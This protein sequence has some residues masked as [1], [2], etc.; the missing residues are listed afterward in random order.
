[1][2]FKKSIVLGLDSSEF[3]KGM[4]SANSEVDKFSDNLDDAKSSIDSAE[5][6]LNGLGDTADDAG[7]AVVD[8]SQQFKN[9]MDILASVAQ[10]IQTVGQASLEYAQN[11]SNM[12]MQTGTSTEAI[13]QLSYIAT[14]TGTDIEHVNDAITSLTSAMASASSG[15]GTAADVFRQLDIS[16]VDSNGEMRD[17]TQVF[18][19]VIA[20]LGT[21]TNSTEA[22]QNAI[23]LFGESAKE[24]NGMIS[25]GSEGLLEMAMEFNELGLGVSDED[26]QS[27]IEAQKSIN[28]MKQAFLAA[29]AELMAT[30]APVIT[31]ITQFLANL[32]PETKQVIM[33]VAALTATL[34]GLTLA[35]SAVGVI[36]T[37]M[38]GIAGAAT[39]AFTA[40]AAPVLIVIAALAAL[41]VAIKE[42][43]DTYRQWKELTGNDSFFDFMFNPYGDNNSGRSGGGYSRNAKGTNHWRGGLTWVGE[44]GP[45]LVNVPAGSRIYN[46][47]QST[48]IGGNTYNVNMSMDMSKMKSINDVVSAVEGLKTSAGCVR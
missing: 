40:Q 2:A 39:A 19:E 33:V 37:T 26:I 23:T 4:A 16:I 8:M 6:E 28:E 17:A 30:F 47:E 46:N 29:A 44:E 25:L 9:G 12:A 35:I 10:T 11:I 41:A 34:I 1:M 42:L 5:D 7:K 18:T 45:E 36:Y 15:S 27:L 24:L 31:S 48:S 43:I 22:S 14:Q 38:I 21:L 13:Q 32:S 3:E 20:K